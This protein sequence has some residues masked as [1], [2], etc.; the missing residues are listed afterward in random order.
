M[1]PRV[2]RI[3]S[4]GGEI[5]VYK[6]DY[7]MFRPVSSRVSFPEVEE[8]I[9]GLWKE[10]NAFERSVEARR[11]SPRFVFYEGPPTA[12]GSPGIHHVLARVFKDVIPRYKAMRGA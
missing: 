3:S 2:L 10:K 5:F 12:N 8:R 7:I 4:L 11:G 6:G 9:L 1:V